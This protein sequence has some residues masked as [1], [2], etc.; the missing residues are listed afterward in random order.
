MQINEPEEMDMIQ[1]IKRA[2]FIDIMAKIYCLCSKHLPDDVVAK[3][4]ELRTKEDAPMAKNL[5]RRHV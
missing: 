1:N 3:L 5:L 4:K 2:R